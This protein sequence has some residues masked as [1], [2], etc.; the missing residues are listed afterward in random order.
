MT[1]N[2]P[3]FK[4]HQNELFI[5]TSLLNN[6][7]KNS[8]VKK[9][10]IE[11]TS[12]ELWYETYNGTGTVKFKNNMEYTGNLHYGII[13][14]KDP[15]SPCTLIFP[16]GTK[17][18]GTM[19]NNEITGKGEYRFHNG[20][21]YTGEVLN[22]LRHGKGVFKTADGIVYDGD[23]RFGLKHGVGKLV[24][25]EMELEG[26]WVDG[27][28]CGKSRIK[29]KSGNIYDGEISE[30]QMHGNGYM[31][32]NDKSEKYVGKWE[33]NLQNGLGI[34]IWYDNKISINKFFKD[35]YVGEWKEGKRD[36]FGKFFYSN[37]SIFEGFWK[38]DKKEGFGILKF[39]DR[40]KLIGLFHNDIFF[41]DLQNA[42]LFLKDD[43]LNSKQKE[44][45]KKLTIFKDPKSRRNSFFTGAI[46]NKQPMKIF[47]K[48]T[49]RI[50]GGLQNNKNDLKKIEEVKEKNDKE[51]DNSKPLQAIQEKSEKTIKD[52]LEDIKI[53]ISIDDI[54]IIDPLDKE[55]YKKIDDLIL[56]NLSLISK[57]YIYATFGDDI[58]LSDIG[59]STG[60]PSFLSETKS[61]S[62]MFKQQLQIKKERNSKDF[63][64]IIDENIQI[65]N[66]EEKKEINLMDNVYNND[67]YFCLDLK[68]FWKLLR[69][70]GLIT[71]KFSLAMIDRFIFKNPE[72]QI[73]MFF[74]PEELEK[75]NGKN[76]NVDD[77]YNYLYHS[78]LD[79]KKIFEMQNK[80]KID[81]SNK[82]LNRIN[83]QRQP[84]S[85]YLQ[86][87]EEL[88]NNTYEK[89]F[90]YHDEKNVI[91]LRYF[92]EIL[93]RL[94]YLRFD[95]DPNLDIEGR[96]KKF[97]DLIKAF[98]KM[99]RKTKIDS[100][101][102]SSVIDPKLKNLD[103]ALE[104]Y[105]YNHYEI[106]KNIFN[107]LY[108]ISCI[109]EKIYTPY[110]MT[111]TYR[112]FFDNVIVNSEKLSELFSDK[113]L[114]IDLI[115]WNF[116]D[117]KI[118]SK[119]SS[120]VED[121]VIFQYCETLYDYEMIFREFCELV[122]Y[123]S[124]KY[125]MFYEID[126]KWEDNKLGLLIKDEE[127]KIEEEDK[128][129]KKKKKT[130]KIKNVDIYMMV[131]DE[132]LNA[133]NI[134]REKIGKNKMNKYYYPILKTH[135]I[136]ERN[137]E[138]RRQ[139]IL[140]EKMKE[141]DKIR[142]ENER[143]TLK[144][145]DINIYKGEDEPKSN[146]EEESSEYD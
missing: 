17:Y 120:N 69:E 14:N 79:S 119:N 138:E 56:R 48:K 2:K 116:R 46:L 111:I 35:R 45:S 53:K 136:I 90:D 76:E 139:R 4:L 3:N 68:N 75:L 118:T 61:K 135:K 51:K 19:I 106:L 21:L 71:P 41:S 146:S 134:L 144:E 125:F 98:M 132:I 16:S 31:V 57:L 29:W 112:F 54:S 70:S 33:N 38:N 25:G 94:A 80:S 49:T 58:K 9:A 36:G 67:L 140:E 65:N 22:G 52:P 97:L 130:K 37:G 86:S 74:I 20:S 128:K 143:R 42:H 145:E 13:N 85:D 18:I 100:S 96:L 30:N 40:S 15:E 107:D 7:I 26:K 92:Y 72:N 47:E 102:T 124:R 131:L 114:Y 122:F 64:G 10:I 141:M 123:I 109:N 110:D 121:A 137:E 32:W 27:V 44:G 83:R 95:E 142:Y 129:I 99:R 60:S 105:I 39:H 87:K 73:D 101:L 59:F 6:I 89:F 126:T 34:Y 127:K 11:E 12:S 8:T 78:I 23:W 93:V 82:I 84:D 55:I 66:N 77:I 63:N 88:E 43:N 133:K 117:K 62:I 91:L 108:K 104:N 103:D 28:I 81:L 24:Q 113:M 1:E 50:I 5:S 115:S